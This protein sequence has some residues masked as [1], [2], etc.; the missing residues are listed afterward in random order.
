MSPDKAHIFTTGT[1]KSHNLQLK[2]PLLYLTAQKNSW[3]HI[4]VF[5][6]ANWL[7]QVNNKLDQYY[8]SQWKTNACR[9]NRIV[10]MFPPFANNSIEFETRSVLGDLQCHQVEIQSFQIRFTTQ[11]KQ[12]EAWQKA[13]HHNCTV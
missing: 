10:L 5:S 6:V 2:W 7:L 1:Q 4:I 3:Q 9:T 13:F 11:C 12:Y 8:C